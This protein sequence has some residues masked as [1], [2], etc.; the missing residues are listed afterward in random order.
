MYCWPQPLLYLTPLERSR[1]VHGLYHLPQDVW[2]T[3]LSLSLGD[4][5]V[6]IGQDTLSFSGQLNWEGRVHPGRAGLAED[7]AAHLSL[8]ANRCFQDQKCSAGMPGALQL[9]F[10][11]QVSKQMGVGHMVPAP[12]SLFSCLSRPLSS[13][14]RQQNWPFWGSSKGPSCQAPHQ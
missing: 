4:P 2:L 3:A 12:M 6:S 14:C 11:L 1:F 10:S 7:G 13:Q 8:P 9:I 5:I